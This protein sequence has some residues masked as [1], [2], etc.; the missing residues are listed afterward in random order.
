[1]RNA[2]KFASKPGTL[3]FMVGVFTPKPWGTN[4]TDQLS[5]V[6]TAVIYMANNLRHYLIGTEMPLCSNL[7]A[8]FHIFI[9]VFVS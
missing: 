3:Q 9:L 4:L 2:T 6:V 1:M 8:A 7:W 5:L